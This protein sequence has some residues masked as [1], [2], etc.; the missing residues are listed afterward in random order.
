M[1]AGGAALGFVNRSAFAIATGLGTNTTI[2]GAVGTCFRLVDSTLVDP[3]A[4]TVTA[5]LVETTCR[6][7]FTVAGTAQG[8][9]SEEAHTLAGLVVQI[10]AFA[11]LHTGTLAIPTPVTEGGIE[12][13]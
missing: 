7:V 3:T 6:N 13:A 1:W 11:L 5:G 4:K 12:L 8:S 10:L 2:L 9:A